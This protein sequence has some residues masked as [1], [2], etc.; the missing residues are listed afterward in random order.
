MKRYIRM[1]SVPVM[2][3]GNVL[4]K[5]TCWS[6]FP[7]PS[8]RLRIVFDILTSQDDNI[9]APATNMN[10]RPILVGLAQLSAVVTV[11]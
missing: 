2:Y 7:A 10:Y 5:H 1:S 9:N 3:F 6:P 8:I 11:C 4:N